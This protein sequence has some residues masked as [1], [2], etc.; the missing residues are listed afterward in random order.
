MNP[1]FFIDRPVFAAVISV[2]IVLAGALAMRVLPIAQYPELTPPQ[3]VVSATYP[4]ASAETVAQTVAAPLEQQINGVEGMLYMQSTNSSSGSMQLSVTFA[5]GTDPDQATID[6]NNRVQRA[7]STLPE[8]V[9]RQGVTV[10]KR[11]TSILGMVAMFSKDPRY[12]RTYVG[13]YALLNVVD[14]LKRIPG[15]GDASVLGSVEY[16]MRIWLRPD[17]LAEFN[18]TPTDVAA[19]IREQNAQFAAG[20]FGDE[21]TDKSVA[22]T[23]SAT[24]QGRL[25]DKAAFEDI[26]LR[27]NE[28]AAA[29]RLKDVAR[30]ELGAQSYTVTAQ[31][32]GTP[33]VPIAIY[34]QPGA[35]A[36][37]TM[38]A[39]T[40]RMD[41][42][43]KA[44]PEGIDY[45]VPFNTT[46]FI[47]VSVE[48]VIHT[49]IE[50]I[51]L[52]VAVV[53]LFLQNWRATLIP[54]IAVPISIIGTFA[55]M[56]LFGFS[57]NLLTLFGLV[58]AI[59]IVVDDAIVVLENVERIMST[60][61]L[62]PRKAAIKAMGEVTGPVIAIV[63]V[64]CAVFV[65][66]TFMGGLAG[67]MYKQ[68]AVTIAISVTISGI[69][70]LTLTPALCA[71]ILKPGHHEPALPF[72]LFNRAFDKLTA[73]Y[74]AGVRFLV[75]RVVVGLLISAGVV[76][77]TA[78]LFMTIPGSLVPDEDQ[79]IM[80]SVAMLPPAASL[81][82]TQAVVDAA[83]QNFQNHP[84]V[85]SV[86]AVSGFDLL[87][88]GMKTSA[89]TSFVSLKDWA[90][91]EAPELDARK[92][93]GPFMGM[94][95]GIKDGMVLAFNPPP[96]MGLS[97]TGG[98]ELYLQDR[99]GGGVAS[100]NAATT[101]LVEAASKRPELTGVRTTFSTNVPQYRI[102]LD[103]DKAKALN[104]PINSVF[105]AMQST[106]GN[107]YVN[108]FTLF[109]RNYRVMLQ[110]ESNF[111]QTPDDLRHVFV[112][113]AAGS[114][115]PLSTLVTV[116]RVI[117][118][119]Q[120]E[121]FNAF[122]AA[123]VTG[124]PAP[125][126]TSGQAIAAMQEVAREALPEGFQVA[127]T[128]SAYQE[129]E[130]GGTGS[131]AMIFGL[132]MVFLILAAQYEKWSLPLAVITAVPFALFGALVAIWLRGLTN[133]VY[134]QIGLV[135]LIGLAAKN[136][137]LIVEFA[138][139]RRQEGAS[140]VEAAID[141]ARLRFRPI[142]M[143]SLAFILGVVP[144]A[145]STGAGSA[146]RH[147]I[148]TGVIGGMLAATFIATFLIPMFY[149]LIAWKQPKAREEDDDV[150][151]APA[152]ET[153]AR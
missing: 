68:F 85:E 73:G 83:S 121:R 60:E 47:Q 91:R 126:Y 24:T 19:A 150:L 20:R 151:L 75:R 95:A 46:K 42:L 108:D 38:D 81:S 124:N 16:S 128:G 113:T 105:E 54:V 14:E 112:K 142:V 122:N 152:Q 104:V 110:S 58:L 116:E 71:L 15:V 117:G 123:K 109:G 63:L 141:A 55:G 61:H 114:M 2:V 127:W 129:L 101:K 10:A 140:A 106:F 27:S 107:L 100:L 35:N 25:P 33:A 87:S 80:F 145:I 17:K 66:V 11:S 92:L 97:T 28:N 22:F 89:G 8:E 135:T 74:T 56:Y 119:D 1:R 36:L 12:D 136:A 6:V 103:R 13:N 34:L 133:D 52:V 37:A 67:E 18:L 138:V 143:T 26:I 144:L 147:S 70:A 88:S 111:R 3:V 4:G 90:E 118:P 64:L 44:F 148:G 82:R 98:F 72:R 59:G 102:N 49:F 78:Y 45:K 131:Q 120:L 57:I 43:K 29:L 93:A 146:S 149:R 94:N 30:V 39:L 153:P 86:F 137:I 41:E 76:G 130:T 134:F 65:P 79:G 7:T 50:A 115:I 125:G 84:A 53:F 51:I 32:N 5:L 69:V 62:S 132:I 96:I 23:Y 40:G 21:P 99:T 31:L 48:E 139:L 77:A 9:T